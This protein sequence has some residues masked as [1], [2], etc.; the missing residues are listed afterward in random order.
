M[1][2]R[3]G[4]NHL[5]NAIHSRDNPAMPPTPD[6]SRMDARLARIEKGNRFWRRY[7]AVSGWMLAVSR[8]CSRC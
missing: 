1:D 4:G 3:A 6:S 8:R 2:R 7:L 5:E